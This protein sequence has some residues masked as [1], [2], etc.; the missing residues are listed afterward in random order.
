MRYRLF[1]NKTINQVQISARIN[2]QTSQLLCTQYTNPG[3]SSTIFE[4]LVDS[5][6]KR[7]VREILRN[8]IGCL[9]DWE[10]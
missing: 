3:I 5:G 10:Y 6:Q 4:N 2:G 1:R 8:L 9:E 7:D